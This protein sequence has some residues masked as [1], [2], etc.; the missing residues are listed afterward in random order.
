MK[1]EMISVLSI[2]ELITNY[3]FGLKESFS[4]RKAPIVDTQSVVFVW[5]LT[6]GL[7]KEIN[8]NTFQIFI[9]KLPKIL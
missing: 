1:T 9:K 8:K 4:F 6:F 3:I 7:L 2:D 5:R